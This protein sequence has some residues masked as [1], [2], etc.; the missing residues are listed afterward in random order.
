MPHDAKGRPLKAG[1]TV[2]IPC[3]ITSIAEGEYCTANVETVH[4]MPGN[5]TKSTISALNAAQLELVSSAE[6]PAAT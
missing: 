6:P 5:G 1:D 4:V 3:V 2:N